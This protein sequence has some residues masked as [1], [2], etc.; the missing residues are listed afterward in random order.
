M[1]CIIFGVELPRYTEEEFVEKIAPLMD[2]EY[3]EQ[4][5]EDAEEFLINGRIKSK[6]RGFTGVSSLQCSS[7]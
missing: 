2:D 3:K 5:E 7:S 1:A 6:C 4:L